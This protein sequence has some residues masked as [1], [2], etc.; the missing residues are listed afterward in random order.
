[1]IEMFQVEG[2]LIGMVHLRALP[3][4]PRYQDNWS[5]IFSI[6]M[7]EAEILAREGID[8]L[9]LENMHDVPYIKGPA[10]PATTAC[11]AVIGREIKQRFQLPTGI[12]VLAGANQEALAVSLAGKLDFVRV[13]GFVFGHVGDEGYTDAQAGP[14]LRYRKQ[15]GAEGIQVWAD[16]KKKHSSHAITADVNLAETA[17]AAAF[18]DADALVVTGNSTGQSADPGE[19]ELVSQASPLPA[20]VGSGIHAGNLGAYFGKASAF[21]VG[22]SLKIDAYWANGIDPGR[23]RELVNEAKRLRRNQ[24]GKAGLG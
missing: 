15:I 17:Q 13:E 20:V 5:E 12:Q 18:F 2:A 10:N 6:A 3:G 14:L 7:E 11:M 9:L 19:V 1:M 8:G 22:S 24:I 21:I 16:I 4:A 23:V